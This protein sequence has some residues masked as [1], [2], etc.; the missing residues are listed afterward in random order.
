MA[1][2]SGRRMFI[3][4]CARMLRGVYQPIDAK[5]S[6]AR[7]HAVASIQR[8]YD[9]ALLLGIREE[10]HHLDARAGLAQHIESRVLVWDRF[11]R[12]DVRS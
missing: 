7:D 8:A 4:S 9:C 5:I 11:A 10:V 2:F 6:L 12:G 1:L 3:V